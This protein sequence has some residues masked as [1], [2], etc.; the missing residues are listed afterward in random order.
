LTFFGLESWA[1]GQHDQATGPYH[2]ERR[3]KENYARNSQP[4]R[5]RE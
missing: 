4:E 1:C 3:V 5:D 2:K